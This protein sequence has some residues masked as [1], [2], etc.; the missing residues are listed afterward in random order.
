MKECGI[1][2]LHL[3]EVQ[4]S[5]GYKTKDSAE[6]FLQVFRKM[7]QHKEWPVCFVMT[8]TPEARHLLDLDPTLLRRLKPMHMHPISFVEDGP[9]VRETEKH[10]FADAG[11]VD[12]SMVAIGEFIKMLMHAVAGRFGVL[13]EMTIE[14][15]GKCSAESNA[16]IEIG[17]FADTY[18][19]RMGCDDELNLFLAQHWTTIDTSTAV[20]RYQKQRQVERR[21][22]SFAATHK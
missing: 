16:E 12:P 1:A 5:G 17:H 21:R 6:A 3:D 15:V 9:L 4:D 20:Q 8:A 13:V 2:A 22:P 19:M 11:V 14:A 18:E 7:M 10:L